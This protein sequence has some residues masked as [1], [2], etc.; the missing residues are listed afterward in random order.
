[1]V[2]WRN[3]RRERTIYIRSS[4]HCVQPVLEF[5]NNLWGLATE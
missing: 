3:I 4:F 5:K 2:G 1:M